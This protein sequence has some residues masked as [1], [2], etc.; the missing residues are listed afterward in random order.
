MATYKT[1]PYT[2]TAYA[3][4]DWEEEW[5]WQQAY[6]QIKEQDRDF[7]MDLG[8]FMEAIGRPL[9]EFKVTC[10]VKFKEGLEY[11]QAEVKIVG[12]E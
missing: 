9:Y 1:E 5:H 11:P 12:A 2:F 6:D 10:E 7:E 4:E 3:H 8:D